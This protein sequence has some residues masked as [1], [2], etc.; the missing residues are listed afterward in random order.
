MKTRNTL[1]PLAALLAVAASLPAAAQTPPPPATRTVLVRTVPALP[2]TF[3][4]RFQTQ[5]T[6]ESKL[7]ANVSARTPGIVQDIYV[8]EGDPVVAGETVLFQIDPVRVRNALAIATQNLAVA[9]A[10]LAVA[11]ANATQ[12]RAQARKAALD[13]QRYTRLHDEGRVT[14]NEY[15]TRQVADE[16]ARAAIA[17][18][19]AQVDL[20]RRQVDSALAAL[21]IA[22]AD[23]DDA[24]VRA[25]LTGVVTER[26]AEPGEL[27]PAGKVL[28]RIEDPSSV[29]A[30]AYLPAAYYTSVAPSSTTFRLTL[31]GAPAGTFPLAYRAP[32]VNPTLRTFEVK[33]PVSGPAA[34]PGLDADLAFVFESRTSLG[35]PSSAVL[36]RGGA[37]TV[38]VDE[39]GVAAARAVETGLQN[40]G[41]TE[42]L[43]GLSEN[44]PVVVEGQTLLNPGAPIQL[45]D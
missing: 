36:H 11:E 19:D 39:N 8:D 15:E 42:I 35:V 12:T 13:F 3:E 33:G 16:Q 32:V 30:V 10:S 20:A 22:Q 29:E 25:P 37:A 45:R 1:A 31:S 40:D 4:R 38:F 41:Y 9:R 17:V 6:L 27:A 14:D 21:A 5:G 7:Y 2:R 23:C 34:V 24:T 26:H 18:A 28:L 44:D 43:S